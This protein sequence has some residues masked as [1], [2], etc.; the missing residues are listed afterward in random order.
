[1]TDHKH[2]V[3]S[4]EG[5]Q[6]AAASELVPTV[7]G[8][9]RQQLLH[10]G[11][12]LEGGL[13]T[14]FTLTSKK[15]SFPLKGLQGQTGLAEHRDQASNCIDK[16]RRGRRVH[17]GAGGDSPTPRPLPHEAGASPSTALPLASSISDDSCPVHSQG[18]GGPFTS[19]CFQTEV[20]PAKP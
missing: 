14:L 20:S 4:G 9:G 1:M 15:V 17:G 10:Q 8:P 6:T 18:A 5:L 11:S 7:N 13:S 3:L 19:S 2:R 16:T 12:D